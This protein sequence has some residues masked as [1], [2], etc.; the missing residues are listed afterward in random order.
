MQAAGG[1]VDGDAEVVARRRHCGAGGQRRVEHLRGERADEAAALG[2]RDELVR[3][4]PSRASGCCHRTSASTLATRPV[5][6]R[7]C[8]WTCT[9]ISPCCSAAR[10][11]ETSVS[12]RGLSVSSSGSYSRRPRVEVLA[13]YIAMSARLSSVGVSVACAGARATPTEAPISTSRPSS[14]IGLLEG[15]EQRVGRRAATR[16]S[17]AVAGSRTANSSPPSR[18]TVPAVP[19]TRSSRSADLAQEVVA[20]LVPERVVDLLELVEVEDHDGRAG[21]CGRP[22]RASSAAVRRRCRCV[23]F[24]RPVR[25]SCSE[26]WR[27]WPMSSPLRSA[28]PAWLATVSS[29]RTS[30]SLEGADV[31]EP[32]GDD[33]RP[34]DAGRRR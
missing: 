4:R 14:A 13:S 26:S 19:T 9:S 34:D 6:S 32:V 25:A 1:E 7:A 31:A 22:R 28:T 20:L 27:S 12:R 17:S 10:S 23:R 5:A 30:S 15:P 2:D 21:R 29:S 18:A 24:G 33:E 11:S 16:S 3:A 8:G